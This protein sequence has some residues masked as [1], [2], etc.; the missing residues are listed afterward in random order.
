MRTRGSISF[1]SADERGHG[2]KRCLPGSGRGFLSAR[3]RAFLRDRRG[4][5]AIEFALGT[6]ALISVSALCFDL[7]SRVRAEAACGRMAAAMAEHVSRD[8]TLDGRQMKALGEFLYQHDLGIPASLVYVITAIR[9]PADPD[10]PPEVVYTD[11]TLRI[12][13]EGVA[14]DLAAGCPRHVDAD[15]R[16]ALPDGFVMSPDEIVLIAEVC[17]RLTR[18]GSLTGRFLAGDVYRVHAL[19][20]R[21]PGETP[22]APVHAERSGGRG[23]DALA[24]LRTGEVA[25]A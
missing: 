24:S 16:P 25:R 21:V 5:A 13:D 20:F 4:V 15:R 8:V 18:E 10:D 14:A 19:P 2:A 17:V 12:G 23:S 7:Y 6:V 9:Q 22:A 3:L 1:P 11:D